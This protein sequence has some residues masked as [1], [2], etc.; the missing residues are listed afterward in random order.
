MSANNNAIMNFLE[1]KLMPIAA[2]LSEQRHLK[3][4]RDG[5]ISTIPL[6]IIGGICLILS[7]PPIDPARTEATNI[8][9][10]FLLAWYN[11][12][13]PNMEAILT[14]YNMSM[15]IM[16]VFAAFG[17]GYSL[18][19]HYSEEYEMNPLSSAIISAV[20]F[21]LVAAPAQD[22]M[23]P[24]EF[25]D[26]K[27]LFTA[28]IVGLVTVEI[29]RILVGR[30]MAIK[31]PDG[32]PP[33]VAA[34]FASLVPM[35]VNVALFYGLNLFLYSTR[36][37]GLTETIMN[38]LTPA[39]NAADSLWFMIII[40]IICHLLWFVGVHGAILVGTITSPFFA[41]NILANAAAKVAGEP[42]P[43]IW[44]EPMW[45]FV[46]VLGGSGATFALT[47]LMLRSSSSQLKTV[48][49]IGLLPALFNINEP[50]LFGTPLILNPLMMAPLILAPVAN[51]IIVY[52][53]VKLGF[54]GRVYVAAPWT[55]PAFLGLPLSNM[56]WKGIIVVLLALLVNLAI[57][58]PFFKSYERILLSETEEKAT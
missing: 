39:I 43:H 27:G 11:W 12:A 41:S 53:A 52:F 49:R 56:D 25:L 24:T 9:N 35:L 1:E 3:A 8:L 51:T 6:T 32:V 5:I 19:K 16:A 14:P 42:L 26:A 15:A 20:V 48:G 29:T 45:A 34:P 57:Y 4:I 33:A 30:G 18:A 46:I 37:T 36:G 28:M 2:K 44:T 17:I 47:L 40:V 38:I 7:F 31:M 13:T 23:I 22:E 10:K 55:T 54:I 58:Y 21:L 50:I